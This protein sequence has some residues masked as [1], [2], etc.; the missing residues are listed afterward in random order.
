MFGLD[1][2]RSIFSICLLEKQVARCSNVLECLTSTFSHL[3]YNE[4][5]SIHGQYHSL[6]LMSAIVWHL[7]IINLQFDLQFCQFFKQI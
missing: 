6:R 7:E 2:D 3:Y 1:H 5:E 4:R